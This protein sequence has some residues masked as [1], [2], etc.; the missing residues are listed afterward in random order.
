MLLVMRSQREKEK[1]RREEQQN[2][3]GRRQFGA[4]DLKPKKPPTNQ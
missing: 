3:K 2:Q 4:N 1:E